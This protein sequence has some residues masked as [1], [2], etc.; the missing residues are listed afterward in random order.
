MSAVAVPKPSMSPLIT[1]GRRRDRLPWLLWIGITV[2]AAVIAS[3][4]AW[5]LRSLMPRGSVSVQQLIGFIVAVETEL[6]ISTG[7]W[8]VLRHY[9]VEAYWWIPAS[10]AANVLAA[11]IIVPPLIAL[12][13][14]RG[15]HPLTAGGALAAGMLSL[16]ASTLIIG[17]AQ[18]FVFREVGGKLAWAWVPASVI[19]GVLAAVVTNALT[20]P[21]VD[22][23]IGRGWPVVLLIGTLAALGALVTSACQAPIL[24]RLLR[25]R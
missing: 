24:M 5:Q 8:L 4:V 17:A 3:L 10:V 12:A 23:V 14:A 19:G 22:A 21:L 20:L 18:A 25:Y 9:K 6:V 16:G 11:V 7:Q 15:I 1:I 13:L 2:L